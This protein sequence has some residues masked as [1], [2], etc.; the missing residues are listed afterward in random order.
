MN[1]LIRSIRPAVFLPTFLIL[2]LALLLSYLQLEAFLE[3]TQKIQSFILVNFSWAFSFVSFLMV[4]LVLLTYC[5]KIGTIRIGGE[6]AKPVLTKANWFMLTLS[7]TTAVGVLFWTTAEPL[8]HLYAPPSYSGIEPNSANAANF[9]M[10]TMFLHWTIT[11]Y[12]IYAIC[13]L[14]AALS[15]YN[16]KHKFTIGSILA[17]IIGRKNAEKYGFIVDI[18]ALFALVAG[19]SSSLGTGALTL[20][21]G[22]SQYIG[23]DV[24]PLRLG[25]IIFIIVFTFVISAAS[26]LHRGLTYLSQVNTWLMLALGIFV[27]LLGPTVFILSLGTESIGVYLG[28]FFEKSLFTGAAGNDSWAH[29]WTIF[30]LAV[31]FAWA[32]VTAVFLGKI[33]KGYTVREFI[34]FTM[35]YPAIF[36]MLWICIFSGI[37]IFIDT[38]TDG[39]LYTILNEEGIEQLLYAVLK[40]L[41]LSGIVIALLLFIAFISFVTAADSSTDAIGNLCTKDY[42]ADKDINGNPLIK[43]IWGIIIGILGW[44]MV[45]FVGIDG[46]KILSNLGGVPGILIAICAIASL[47]KWLSHPELL[48]AN[49]EHHDHTNNEVSQDHSQN[50]NSLSLKTDK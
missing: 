26:G 18:L 24:S 19:I 23:G 35:F 46:V 22:V 14:V 50:L 49:R 32:P 39:S 43:I 8:Y 31:W 28:T 42:R 6:K 44:V 3:I 29:S 34:R 27:F 33:S 7:T 9:S 1:Q 47:I 48:L 11:P 20:A 37:T 21:G 5:S 36:C 45:A 10:A 30:Y 2:V 16:L 12:S 41:P 13:A 40:T 15:F 17:P 25:I 38:T 4:M